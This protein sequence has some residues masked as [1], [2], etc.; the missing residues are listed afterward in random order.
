MLNHAIS[1]QGEVLAPRASPAREPARIHPQ[2]RPPQGLLGHLMPQSK[3]FNLVSLG[4]ALGL[5]KP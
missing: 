3:A 4:D 1:Q 2:P 5:S